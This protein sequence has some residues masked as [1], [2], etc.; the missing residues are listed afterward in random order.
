MKSLR[1]VLKR[2]RFMKSNRCKKLHGDWRNNEDRWISGH[3]LYKS[4]RLELNQ[5]WPLTYRM[6]EV[7]LFP[8][9]V[10]VAQKLT[11]TENGMANKSNLSFCFFISPNRDS[12]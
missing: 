11:S 9:A 1:H 10:H 6:I 7:Q 4:W 2:L 8:F 5:I 12:N 3:V